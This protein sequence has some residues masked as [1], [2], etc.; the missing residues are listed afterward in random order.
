MKTYIEGYGG[1]TLWAYDHP[2]QILGTRPGAGEQPDERY[3]PICAPLMICG[4]Y[5]PTHGRLC[6]VHR[7]NPC[8]THLWSGCVVRLKHVA[9]RLPFGIAQNR[10]AAVRLN[11]RGEETCTVGFLTPAQYDS[12]EYHDLVG[13]D[14]QVVTL[15]RLSRDEGEHETDFA[16]CGLARCLSLATASNADK[17]AVPVSYACHHEEDI[18]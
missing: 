6:T 16:F 14:A 1:D 7:F 15:S 13:T 10:I 17:R 12:G 5:A 11:Q 2:R 18:G 4:L 3:N 8:G 9:V